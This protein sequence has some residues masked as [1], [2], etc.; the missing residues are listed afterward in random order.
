M[1]N[2]GKAAGTVPAQCWRNKMV[3]ERAYNIPEVCEIARA[4]RTSV[5]AAIQSGELI[6]RKRGRRTIVLKA[7]LRQWLERLPLVVSKPNT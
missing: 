4:G 7:D 1:T 6:A 2:I 5:Y 3:E